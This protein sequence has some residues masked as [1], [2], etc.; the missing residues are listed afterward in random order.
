MKRTPDIEFACDERL[1]RRVGAKEVVAD[2]VRSNSL[3][4][5]IS[6]VREKYGDIKNVPLEER[7]GVAE[8]DAQTACNIGTARNVRAVCVDE[9]SLREPGHALIALVAAPG[10]EVSQNDNNDARA[11]LA[12]HMK[13]RVKPQRIR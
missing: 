4:L 11:A 12:R 13:I 10:L 7:N 3:R 5:Q 6:V 8:I 1:W 2:R 9:P